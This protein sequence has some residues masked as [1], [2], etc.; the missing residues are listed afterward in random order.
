MLT[1]SVRKVFQGIVA[2]EF[3]GGFFAAVGDLISVGDDSSAGANCDEGI[4]ANFL[5]ADHTFE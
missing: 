5:P 4:A 2:L 3:T 1:D